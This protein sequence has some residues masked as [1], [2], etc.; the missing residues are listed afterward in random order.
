VPAVKGFDVDGGGSVEV[1]RT[2][3]Q[4]KARMRYIERFSSL[5]P[6]Y[7]YVRGA[8]LLRVSSTLTPRQARGYQRAFAKAVR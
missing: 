5:F 1:F 3:S 7:D 2:T 8:V 4:A 6:E